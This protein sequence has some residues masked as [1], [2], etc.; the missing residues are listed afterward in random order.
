MRHIPGKLN[1]IAD[2]LSRNSQ[3]LPTGW[4]LNNRVFLRLCEFFGYLEIDLFATR[5]NRKLT[6]FVS[7]VPDPLAYAVDSMSVPWTGMHGYASHDSPCTPKNLDRQSPSPPYLS[8]QV[9]QIL[10][11]PSPVHAGVGPPST[12]PAQFPSTTD[13]QQ[14]ETYRFDCAQPSRSSFIRRSLVDRGWDPDVVEAVAKGKRDSTLK[15]YDSKWKLFVQWCD[16][17]K[18]TPH[19]TQPKDIAA[20]LWFLFQSGRQP[21]TLKGHRSAIANVFKLIGMTWDPGSNYHIT[22]LMKFCQNARP[23]ASV[24][25]PKWD[26][27]LVLT[28]LNS[29]KFEP[30][31]Q[32]S[33]EAI[34]LKTTFLLALATG[35][36]VSE[37]HALSRQQNYIVKRTDGALI[38]HCNPLFLA[39]TQLPDMR[40][41]PIVLL[42]LKPGEV[43]D[44]S[45]CPVRAVNCYLQ[46]TNS[47]SHSDRLLLRWASKKAQIFPQTLSSWIRRVIQ[48]AY[49][50]ADVP[51]PPMRRASHEV[52]A[53][54]A[55]HAYM[56]N[57]S[58]T[59]LLGAVGWSATST[60]AKHYLRE[61]SPLAV[62]VRL[63]TRE[64]SA[65]H[66]IPSDS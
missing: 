40:P 21:S 18:L 61:V 6:R 22:E 62:Q 1:V 59:D 64:K 7:P 58:L 35:K 20:Y 23:R 39:K 32:V 45:L 25:L 52:R 9:V 65:D 36:R 15:V 2:S 57:V 44:L 63:P 60:F 17:N 49:A 13:P 30:M 11:F 51:L 47:V 41:K 16:D 37:L 33:L 56:N 8:P 43:N 29:N 42:P 28:Y 50:F 5:W 27:N 54:A 55:S 53:L 26:L 48:E 3:I 31:C 46:A 66:S 38:L 12:P 34:T 24:R 10:D 4:T 14:C 19:R